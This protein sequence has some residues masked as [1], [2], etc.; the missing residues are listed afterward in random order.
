MT[1]FTADKI[2]HPGQHE[3]E[4]RNRHNICCQAGFL[5]V[6]LQYIPPNSLSSLNLYLKNQED[7]LLYRKRSYGFSQNDSD[8]LLNAGVNFLYVSV[9]DHQSYYQTIEKSLNKVITDPKILTEIK[10]DILYSTSLELADQLM[11]SPPGKEEISRTREVAKSTVQWVITD[12]EAY[13]RL[14]DISSHDFY[15]ATHM[16]NVCTS[17]I[18]V[19]TKMGLDDTHVLEK[20]GTG[21]ILHD[22]G[23]LFVSSEI[24]NTKDKLT[25]A[26]RNAI[27]NHVDLGRKHLEAVMDH[28]DPE[29][30]AVVAE[31]HERMDG[32][33]YPNG[34]KGGRISLIGRLTAIV[35]TF[36]A[37]TSVR[38]YRKHSF[39]VEEALDFLTENS[40]DKYDRDM[41]SVF[42]T[43]ILKS[44][45]RAI[46]DGKEKEMNGVLDSKAFLS[47]NGRMYQRYYFRLQVPIRMIKYSKDRL[48]LEEAEKII[49]HNVSA[50]GI[51]FLSPKPLSI[52]EN[53]CITI[54]KIDEKL[55]LNLS[56]TI[57]RCNDHQD[58]WF[59]IGAK[60][61]K[62]QDAVFVRKF[63]KAFI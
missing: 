20:I 29:I 17:T 2:V 11:S 44:L 27:E 1:E 3:E 19:A 62:M 12:P 50:S 9:Q 48:A 7:Y 26:Q 43:V 53:F 58:G 63:R 60:F 22:I 30:Y 42:S 36:E 54:P 13:N 49:L 38:P 39:S 32:S 61:H 57:V 10:A 23:K 56:A 16:V 8:R 33:G 6:P 47:I 46:S 51:G 35:D 15:T 28:V 34:L 52:D 24:L 41:V 31:H 37:M 55:P 45:N 5:P 59:T 14:A 4:K 40:P 21:A 25:T 18:Y